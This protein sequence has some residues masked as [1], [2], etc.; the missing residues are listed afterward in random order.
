MVDTEEKRIHDAQNILRY[1][2]VTHNAVIKSFEAP[3]GKC[4]PL[5][6]IRLN[7][8]FQ[9]LRQLFPLATIPSLIDQP[10]KKDFF[11]NCKYLQH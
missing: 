8:T 11:T 1:L 9:L 6:N 10:L 7:F 5:P 4:V 3:H 2:F